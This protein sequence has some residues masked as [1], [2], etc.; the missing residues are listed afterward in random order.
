MH[1]YRT[2]LR[3]KQR[4][5]KHPEQILTTRM[6]TLGMSTS[7]L[8]AGEP[9]STKLPWTPTYQTCTW[10]MKLPMIEITAMMGE[11]I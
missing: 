9:G 7:Y 3:F 5:L 8:A 10:V 4:R 2:E 11:D 1:C 6:I